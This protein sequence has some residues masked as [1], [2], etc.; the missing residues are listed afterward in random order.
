MNHGDFAAGYF[1]PSKE[2]LLY[3][4]EGSGQVQNFQTG[5]APPRTRVLGGGSPSYWLN[6]STINDIKVIIKRPTS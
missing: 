3:G 5:Y 6:L 2:E 1:S 4:I